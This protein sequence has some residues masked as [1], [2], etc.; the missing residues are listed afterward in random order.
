[1]F[2]KKLYSKWFFSY[3]GNFFLLILF[4]KNTCDCGIIIC[5]KNYDSTEKCYSALSTV[6][7]WVI[8]LH[9]FNSYLLLMNC[10]PKLRIRNLFEIFIFLMFLFYRSR[11]IYNCGDR[12]SKNIQKRQKCLRHWGKN[13]IKVLK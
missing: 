4:R 8:F 9:L 6:N 2:L 11:S 13:R 12:G 5:I 1:M 7:C 10:Q 3:D